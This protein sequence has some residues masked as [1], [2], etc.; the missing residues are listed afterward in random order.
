M[1]ENSM[2]EKNILT[3]KDNNRKKNIVSPKDTVTKTLIQHSMPLQEETLSFLKGIAEDYGKVRNSVY[4]RYSGIRNIN[5][6][7][8]VYTVLNEM[9]ACGLREQLGLPAVYYEL[10]VSDAVADIKG[11]WGILKNR[12]ADLIRDNENLTSEDRQYLRTILKINSVFSA[13]LN[14][15]P[16][17]MPRNAEGLAIDA[18]RLNNLLCRLVRRHMAVP[19]TGNA[20]AFRVSPNGYKYKDGGIYLVS[21]IPRQRV[22]VPLKDARVFD[23][24]ILVTLRGDRVRLT[25]PVEARVRKHT[26]YKGAI[27]AHIGNRDMLTLSNGNVYG[28]D[29]E[30]RVWPETLRLDRKIRERGTLI[31]NYEK[32]VAEGD[33]GKA[34]SIER[35]NLGKK[36][37]DSEKARQRARTQDYINTEL[38]RMLKWE[39][40]ARIVITRPVTKDE[41]KHRSTTVNLKLNRSFNGYIRNRLAFKCRV[42]SVELVEI[43][44]KGTGSVCAA[45]GAEGKRW[46]G[47]FT[48]EACGRKTTIALNSAVNIEK[49][50]QKENRE[51]TV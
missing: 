25:I 24:Q 13:V 37:Y 15:E 41:T 48:C 26:D 33:A 1:A 19:K 7:T 9:R 16:Y 23:R 29:L 43:N 18:E 2:E 50:F 28:R 27:Y 21:R 14:R 4:Q 17:E 40:P 32:Q 34:L 45:C 8:P 44:S 35:N 47:E 22:F 30:A 42:H 38:N 51:K 49:K 11:N 31:R 6:L 36:K 12:V 10:A 39:K 3:G 20:N 46:K 5:R